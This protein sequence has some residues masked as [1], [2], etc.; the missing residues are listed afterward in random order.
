MFYS[1]K[2]R[3]LVRVLFSVVANERRASEMPSSEEQY[4]ILLGCLLVSAKV[5]YPHGCSPYPL[6]LY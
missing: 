1:E 5:E 2:S 3:L 6:A 4:F